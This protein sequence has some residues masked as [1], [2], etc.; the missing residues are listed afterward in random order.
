MSGSQHPACPA[1][2]ERVNRSSIQLPWCSHAQGRA[3]PIVRPFSCTSN[4]VHVR[5]YECWETAAARQSRVR[6]AA[7][8]QQHQTAPHASNSC[9]AR[10]GSP[11]RIEACP[12]PERAHHRETEPSRI[13]VPCDTCIICWRL[14]PLNTRPT[15]RHASVRRMRQD[16][17]H[18]LH[19][20]LHTL[21]RPLKMKQ[22][23][24]PGLQRPQQHNP[25]P[26]APLVRAFWRT[27]G[28]RKKNLRGPRYGSSN[29]GVEHGLQ[30]PGPCT[31]ECRRTRQGPTNSERQGMW[32]DAGESGSAHGKPVRSKLI[33][34][35]RPTRPWDIPPGEN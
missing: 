3:R 25:P 1:S 22:N 4:T 35:T 34:S 5:V 17:P 13:R 8:A 6:G 20:T 29:Q 32:A 12:R 9:N 18:V 26:D 21:P 15:H 10:D 14:A 24:M 16:V 2:T 33:A 19:Q 30:R 28:R 7:S 31:P 11:T 23:G 27:P